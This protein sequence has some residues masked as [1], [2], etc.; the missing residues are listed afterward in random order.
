[1]CV[2]VS[3]VGSGKHEIWC[4]R[5]RFYAKNEHIGSD[6]AL[7]EPGSKIRTKVWEKASGRKARRPGEVPSSEWQ[8]SREFS[9]TDLSIYDNASNIFNSELVERGHLSG[10]FAHERRMCQVNA[11]LLTAR[12]VTPITQLVVKSFS[13]CG[14]AIG[15]LPNHMANRSSR[16]PFWPAGPD[17]IIAHELSPKGG[18]G[19]PP[20]IRGPAGRVSSWDVIVSDCL[21]NPDGARRAQSRPS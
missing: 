8:N 11:E 1:M 2:S 14:L 4:P 15:L 13:T 6:S 17:R 10:C 21:G 7:S 18:K 19:F 3:L 5:G 20:I 16:P 12:G 9:V